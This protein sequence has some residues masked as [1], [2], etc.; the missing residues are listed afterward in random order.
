[1]INAYTHIYAII[2]AL[3]GVMMLGVVGVELVKAFGEKRKE[4]QRAA[5]TAAQAAIPRKVL[6]L[7]EG[8]WIPEQGRKVPDVW[9]EGVR[10]NGALEYTHNGETRRNTNR[11]ARF[12][13]AD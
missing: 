9:V 2:L 6:V 8:Y 13:F 12:Q 5:A 4:A 10:V 1:M 7:I 3:F 11:F